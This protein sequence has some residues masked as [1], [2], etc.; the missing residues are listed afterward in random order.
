MDVLNAICKWE[1]DTHLNVLKTM[2]TNTRILNMQNIPNPIN[3]F[4]WCNSLQTLKFIE[5]IKTHQAVNI[6]KPYKMSGFVKPSGFDKNP[7]PHQYETSG[8]D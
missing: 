4:S 8:F 2:K 6:S 3:L 1:F 7:N 5:P